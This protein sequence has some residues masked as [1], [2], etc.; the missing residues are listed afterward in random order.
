MARLGRS[1]L[2]LR[3]DRMDALV[4]AIWGWDWPSASRAGKL[5]VTRAGAPAATDAAIEGQA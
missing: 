4:I 5:T 3:D 2:S 1:P